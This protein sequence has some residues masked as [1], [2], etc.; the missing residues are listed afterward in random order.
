MITRGSSTM[1]E[2]AVIAQYCKE[3][4][5]QRA[6]VLSSKFHTRRIGYVMAKVFNEKEVE[7]LVR[8][9]PSSV[10]SESEWWHQ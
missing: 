8:G 6:M 4:G 5:I 3:N 9:A 2:A 1:E 7:I 10:Y